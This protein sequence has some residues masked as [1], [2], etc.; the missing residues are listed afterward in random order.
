MTVNFRLRSRLPVHLPLRP[1]EERFMVCLESESTPPVGNRCTCCSTWE[2]GDS[3]CCRFLLPGVFWIM[4]YYRYTDTTASSC[5]SQLFF[6]PGKAQRLGWGKMR[7]KST[8]A[9]T[10]VS[11]RRIWG[12]FLYARLFLSLV[13]S[14]CR[15]A[16]T[17]VPARRRVATLP[18]VLLC[19]CS[20]LLLYRRER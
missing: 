9:T 11:W 6:T 3:V 14:A 5:C 20:C 19:C 8:T 1:F 16:I 4:V 18:R 17:F 10:A 13:W 7:A 12:C 15:K 2:D